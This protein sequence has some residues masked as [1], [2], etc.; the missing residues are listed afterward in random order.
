MKYIHPSVKLNP[1]VSI[2]SD[3]IEIAENCLIGF[4]AVI[5][6]RFIMGKNSIF[7]TNSV[8][9]GDVVI[10]EHTTVYGN[11]QMASIKIGN[12]CFIGP[13][14][15]VTNTKHISHGKFGYPRTNNDE[16]YTS[17]IEDNVIIG[18]GCVL[19]PG[20]TI[21]FGSRIDLGCTILSDV[22]SNTHVKACTVW[23]H[24]K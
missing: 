16:R 10:G 9:D 12:N 1:F 17:I 21:G 20:V 18:G 19:A 22:P 23:K 13:C 14:I 2:D 3:D 8:S 15:L 24:L 11:A 6:G 7:G 5:R 4:H